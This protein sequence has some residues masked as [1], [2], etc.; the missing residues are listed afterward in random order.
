MPIALGRE[1]FDRA[2]EPKEFY[3]VRGGDHF[4]PW[5]RA[6]EAFEE[7]LCAFFRE[8]LRRPVIR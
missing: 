5:V 6:G 3:E 7:R 8:A 2:S 4:T 1:L